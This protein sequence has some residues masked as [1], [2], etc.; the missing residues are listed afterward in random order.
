MHITIGT[1]NLGKIQAVK[2]A[3]KKYPAYHDAQI[4]GC[5]ITSGVSDQPIGLEETITG[6]K[7]RA[8]A[9]YAKGNAELSIGLESGIFPVPHTKSGYM[10]TTICAIYDGATYHIG[11]SS[12][13]EYPKT[14]ITKV[15][16]E[17]KEIA[18]IA[19]EL[20][21]S[22]HRS[23]KEGLG[24]IGVLTNGVISRIAFT[25]QAVHT[26]L[27]QLLHPDQY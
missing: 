17:Q 3:L 21:F 22:E 23:F 27:L 5:S 2:N 25:E 20:G 12:C 11:F 13:F 9:A 24:M 15:L 19:V 4:Q 18:D 26:A 8:N 10:D 14:M 16:E 6:A 1:E 7:N